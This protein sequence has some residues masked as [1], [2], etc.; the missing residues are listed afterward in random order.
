MVCPS[1]TRHGGVL[2][3]STATQSITKYAGRRL[4]NC[5][6]KIA[7]LAKIAQIA[8]DA[9]DKNYFRVKKKQ[10]GAEGMPVDF[11]HKVCRSTLT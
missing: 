9:T 11:C 2:L 8:T 7:T 10:G 4:S 5:D 1:V 3:L 6:V